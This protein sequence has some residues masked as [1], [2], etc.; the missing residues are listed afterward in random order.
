MDIVIVVTSLVTR[1]MIVE[2]KKKIKL[3]KGKNTL[4]YQM[5]KVLLYFSYVIMLDTLKNIA[6]TIHACYLR[7]PRKRYCYSKFYHTR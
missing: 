5:V 6:R 3:I 2:S 7:K 1:L 4:I